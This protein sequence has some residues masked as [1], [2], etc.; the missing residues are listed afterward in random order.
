MKGPILKFRYV[1]NFKKRIGML[2]GGSGITPMLQ[3]IEEIAQ[4]PHDKTEVDLI[5]ANNTFED[6]LL[7]ERLDAIAKKH[8]NIRVHYILSQSAPEGWKGYTGF[9]SAEIVKKHLGA[10][11]DDSLVLVCGP[12]GF[13]EAVSGNKTPDYKQGEVS[14]ILKALGFKENM[15]FKF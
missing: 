10:P 9:I 11:S 7:K 15:V 3:V 13:M 14:G 1:P 6:I 5:F 2:A 12:P 4:N 8:K